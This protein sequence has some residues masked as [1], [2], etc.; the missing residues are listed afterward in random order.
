MYKD[1]ANRERH[2]IEQIVS[3]M[4]AH[5]RLVWVGD[6]SMAPWELFGQ[7]YA[8]PWGG[9]YQGR[10]LSGLGWLQWIRQKCPSSVWL[11]P[12]P[13]RFWEHPTVTAIGEVFP[14]FPL[15]LDGLRD[16]VRKLQVPV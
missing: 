14:M 11:N 7:Q 3:E 13:E 2:D 5:H 9:G 10:D 1:F 4:S 16:A 12:D 15:T 6:A 8:N